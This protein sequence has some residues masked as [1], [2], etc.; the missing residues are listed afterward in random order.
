MPENKK[1]IKLA[2]YA[3]FCYGVKR[4]VETVK[5]LKNENIENLKVHIKINTGMNRLGIKESEELKEVY[6]ILEKKKPRQNLIHCLIL[7]MKMPT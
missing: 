6:K 4:A 2:K 5:K 7:N 3:G 1:E